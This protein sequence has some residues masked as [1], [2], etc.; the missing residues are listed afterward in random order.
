M[1]T[2]PAARAALPVELMHQLWRYDPESGKLYWRISPA[3]NCKAGSEAGT[4]APEGYIR[5]KY[6]GFRYQAHYIVWAMLHGAWPTQLIDHRDTDG[7][8][9]RED[10]LRVAT[11]SQNAANRKHKPGKYLRGARLHPRN[12]WYA[13]CANT[14]LGMF[15]SEQEAH[16]A[17]RVAAILRWGAF[18]RID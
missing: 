16:D 9:N 12:G 18:A 1:Q 8:N 6:K 4:P 11:V 17:Y 10:N 13:V 7:G 2:S 14:H 3:R 15:A 5:I